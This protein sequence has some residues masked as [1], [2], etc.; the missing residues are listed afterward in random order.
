MNVDRYW[1]KFIKTTLLT[2]K[3][4]FGIF[5]SLVNFIAFGHKFFT[6]DFFR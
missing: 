2:T 4:L 5:L 3:K 1:K 6:F